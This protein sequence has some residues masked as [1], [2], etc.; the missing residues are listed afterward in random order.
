[1]QLKI[2]IHTSKNKFVYF[3]KNLASSIVPPT[4]YVI[5]R[6][7]YNMGYYLTDDVYTKSSTTVQI[8]RVSHSQKKKY[9]AIKQE[10]C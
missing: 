7:E 3:A 6:K 2:T 1:M 9:F 4:H 10:S 8:I 5:Q